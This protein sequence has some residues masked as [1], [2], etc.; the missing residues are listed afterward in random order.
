MTNLVHHKVNLI[1]SMK[2]IV[3]H[4]YSVFHQKEPDKRDRT[5]GL[6]LTSFSAIFP[7]TENQLVMVWD[8]CGKTF[9]ADQDRRSREFTGK[10]VN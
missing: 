2:T 9:T 5:P 10:H 1:Q 3:R 6:F 4:L 7:V 8:S